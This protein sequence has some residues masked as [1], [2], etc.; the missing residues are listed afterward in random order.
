MLKS[1]LNLGENMKQ[2]TMQE[3]LD[4]VSSRYCKGYRYENVALSDEMVRRIC[5]VKGLVNMG[6]A[7]TAITDASLEYLAR[8]PKLSYLSLE[9]SEK[10]SGEGF[11]YFAWHAKLKHI[12]VQNVG[13]T[14][15]GL[16]AI[17]QIPSLKSLR[18]V[19]TRVS[20]AGLLAVADAKILF[21][22]GG[23]R[24]SKEQIAKFEQA[25]R[26]FQSSKNRP[27]PQDAAAAQSALLEFFAAMSKWEK[28][29]ARKACDENK[30]EARRMLDELFARYCTPAKRSGY[31]REFVWF[32]Q[33]DGGT[34]GGY[35]LTD[36]DS[37]TKN[38][39]YVYAKDGYG[40]ARRFLLI[41]K[42]GR[43]LVDKQQDMDG[44][45]KNCGL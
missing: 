10:I 18:I 44:G 2:I 28:F 14:D 34:Y 24:F 6:F 4:A 20:F 5:E 19:D 37:E 11:R 13:I 23:E 22:I 15:E 25:Q 26:D 31:R 17:A 39:F 1:K 38:K 33:A 32:S 16:K 12:D 29:A 7:A 27:D 3:A 9:N 40:F 8:L 30:D 45:W 41:R 42:D 43:W 35:E 21:H 36:V